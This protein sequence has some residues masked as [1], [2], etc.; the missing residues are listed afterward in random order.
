M[1][2][3][4]PLNREQYIAA[5]GTL[6]ELKTAAAKALA[7]KDELIF[8]K[9]AELE[10]EYM[11]KIGR[12]ENEVLYLEHELQKLKR[13]TEVVREYSF[14][15]HEED[16]RLIDMQVALEFEKL[17]SEIQNRKKRENILMDGDLPRPFT[18]ETVQRLTAVYARLAKLLHPELNPDTELENQLR[19]QRAHAAFIQRDLEEIIR[20]ALECAMI[21]E[22][23]PSMDSAD[24]LSER[25]ENLRTMT[26]NINNT[27]EKI[28]G[29]FPFT[30]EHR[31]KDDGW[32]K[33]SQLVNE[34]MLE[35]LKN[36]YNEQLLQMNSLLDQKRTE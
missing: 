15:I 19:W 28:K 4:V 17:G 5:I 27:C 26:A 6:D 24:V 18:E 36:A 7:E 14:H 1:D 32:V 10:S 9:A 22:Y 13:K 23:V 31:L 3:I 16:L 29:E 35:Y 30:Y 33:R 11:Q 2:I 34:G 8:H 12:I 21:C 20:I 25:M